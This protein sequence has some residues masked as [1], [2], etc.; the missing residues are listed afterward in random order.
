MGKKRSW[1]NEGLR[2]KCQ[3]SGKCCVSRG[4]YGYVYLT[5]EDRRR[6]ASHLSISTTAFTRRF[7]AK[8]GDTYYLKNTED[9]LECPY[10]SDNRCS[11]YEARPTQ[12]RTW[13]FWPETLTPK[14]WKSEVVSFCPGANK[15]KVF[16]AQEIDK[17]LL[18]QKKAEREI[19]GSSFK[20]DHY[21]EKIPKIY[22]GCHRRPKSRIFLIRLG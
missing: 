22:L 21:S 11:V 20:L 5:L 18:E 7:C 13:P 8:S 4:E 15:G 1:Y 12:C 9:S 2:F 6:L 3:G 17:I 10:L 19:F 14:K 16:S